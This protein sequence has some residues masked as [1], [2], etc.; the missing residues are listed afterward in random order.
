MAAAAA[1]AADMAFGRRTPVVCGCRAYIVPSRRAASQLGHTGALGAPA[2]LG[3][4]RSLP[5]RNRVTPIL[6][7]GPKLGL[8]TGT[9]PPPP[10]QGMKM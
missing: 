4:R 1:A 2:R 5:A 9:S 10:P 8:N 6:R 7:E 3:F